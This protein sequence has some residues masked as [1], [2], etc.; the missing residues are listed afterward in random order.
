MKTYTASRLSEGNK[1]FPCRV[2]ISDRGVTLKIPGF[3]SG[4]EATI[5][6]GQISGVEINTPMVGYSTITVETSGEG[7]IIAHGFTKSEV[8]E[9]K[10]MIMEK[11]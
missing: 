7:N 3:F 6:F 10:Y 2:T 11:I 8:K 9:M 4:D 5:P 1:V